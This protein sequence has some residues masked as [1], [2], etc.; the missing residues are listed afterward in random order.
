MPL[1]GASPLAIPDAS[2][3][4][5]T[6]QVAVDLPPPPAGQNIA[7]AVQGDFYEQL[8]AARF[9]FQSSVAAGT[10]QVFVFPQD[11]NGVSIGS[12]PA[13]ITQAPNS[14]FGYTVQ[15][16]NGIAY[17][18]TGNAVIV[19]PPMLLLPGYTLN[20]GASG[21]DA[22]DQ[23]SSIGLLLLRIPSATQPHAVT[24]APTP[25]PLLA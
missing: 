15:T 4:D 2:A 3:L 5:A 25:T 22:A 8:L 18:A 1:L 9:I 16:G 12:W 24:V 20:F 21:I 14:N 17:A 19:I 11:P 23:F 10:R 7:H 6:F 13:T